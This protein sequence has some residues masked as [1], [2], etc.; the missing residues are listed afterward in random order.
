MVTP[1]SLD[2]TLTVVPE[3]WASSAVTHSRFQAFDMIA[4]PKPC[5]LLVPP[6]GVLTVI[7][8]CEW[9]TL[10]A[11][12][13]GQPTIPWIF[14]PP[15]WWAKILNDAQSALDNGQSSL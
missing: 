13:I 6:L 10:H 12:L 4:A 1:K 2:V 7:M 14:Q 8:V 15:N 9:Q 3:V 11:N 5:G